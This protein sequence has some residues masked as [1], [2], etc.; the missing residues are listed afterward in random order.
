MPLPM[1]TMS[2][3]PSS[4]LRPLPVPLYVGFSYV[5]SSDMS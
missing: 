5:G 2:Y 4:P 3:S 1:T